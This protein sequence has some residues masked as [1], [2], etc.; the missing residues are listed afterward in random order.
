MVIYKTINL[1]NSKIYIGKDQKNNPNYYGS[2]L[3]LKR[4]IK[5]YGKHNFKKEIIEECD[6]P[7]SLEE[8]EIFWIEKLN[9]EY[10]ITKGG[11]GGDTFTNHPNKNQIRKNKSKALK[12]HTVT[13][14][15]R[16]KLRIKNLGKTHSEET[17]EKIREIVKNNTVRYWKNKKIPLETRKKISNT[18]KGNIP[19]NK[20]KPS[21]FKGVPR[22][23]ETKR[24]IR[25][26]LKTK[27]NSLETRKKMSEAKK[28]KPWSKARREAYLNWK[29]NKEKEYEEK[30]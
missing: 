20:G 21:P 1:I 3:Y 24:R 23:E 10:N 16:E 29:E 4:A 26:A 12:G 17:K 5:K 19:W 11:T 30:N 14:E 25:E 22:T 28:G 27:V 15:T 7:K 8:R 6:S 13:K 9:P 18:L 2:G